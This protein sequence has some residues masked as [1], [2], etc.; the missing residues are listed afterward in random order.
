MW[1]RGHSEKG[2]ERVRGFYWFYDFSNFIPKA[3]R[4]AEYL[5][6]M[7]CFQLII[8]LIKFCSLK[9]ALFYD[10]H[11]SRIRRILLP[12]QQSII[13]AKKIILTF[14]NKTDLQSNCKY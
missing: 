10:T 12:E 11:R 13:T 1:E 4:I 2:G 5:K 14:L 3:P 6:A 8:S 7:P 9:C